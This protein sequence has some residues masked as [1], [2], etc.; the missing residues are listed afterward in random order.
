MRVAPREV[1]EAVAALA[2]RQH[3]VVST[4]QLDAAGLGRNAIAGRVARGWLRRLHRGV[5]VV[6]PLETELTAPAG[7]L[8]AAGDAAAVTHRTAATVWGMLHVRPADPVDITL[9]DAR[10]SKRRGVRVHHANLEAEDLRTRH[11][12]RLSSPART[13]LDLATTSELDKA[14]NEAQVLRLVTPREL[15]S[16]LARSSGHRGVR[17]LRALVEGGAQMTRSEAERQL[18][19]LIQAA[20]LPAPTTNTRVAGHEVDM[21][22][23]AQ[24]LVVEFDGWAAHSTRAAFERDRE[25]DADLLLAGQRVFRV[26]HRQLTRERERLIARLAAARAAPPRDPV[27]AARASPP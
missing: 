5:Y 2:R 21:H 3:G 23:P 19:D 6:G 16:L 12:L 24:R 15:T 18:L 14:L 11:G 1:D 13:L 26:T 27:Q 25:R 7:A 8:L 4:A 22:W 10:S 17:A 20:G 9:L